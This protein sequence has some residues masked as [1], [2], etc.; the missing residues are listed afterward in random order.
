ML[1]FVVKAV[2][3]VREITRTSNLEMIKDVDPMSSYLSVAR[4]YK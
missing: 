4:M 2:L 3:T 1:L